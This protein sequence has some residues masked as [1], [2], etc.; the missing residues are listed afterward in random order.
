MAQLIEQNTQTK[1]RVL[2]GKVVSTKMDK[3]I[4]VSV[5]RRFAHPLLGKTVN[6][7]KKY[8]VHDEKNSAKSGDV[9]AIAEC[10]PI[11]KTKHMRLMHI[12][13]SA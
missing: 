12:I 2:E 1:V 4:V 13:K 10:R 7:S 6:R 9:V 5:T 3:T 11:S 8:K